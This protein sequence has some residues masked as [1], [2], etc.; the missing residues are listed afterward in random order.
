MNKTHKPAVEWTAD[1]KLG[2]EEVDIQ[3]HKLVDMLNEMHWAIRDHKGSTI[4]REILN[5]LLDYTHFHFES[6]EKMM[7]ELN[8]PGYDNHV[9]EHKQLVEELRI[10][11]H[12]VDERGGSIGFE[13]MHFLR[14]WLSKHIINSDKEYVEYFHKM[15]MLP[16]IKD[17]TWIG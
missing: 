2:I 16:H 11:I 15:D 6:E 14:M 12:R 17:G 8:Y 7:R 5:Q 9:I 3:H 10:L 4:G 13:L 1:L